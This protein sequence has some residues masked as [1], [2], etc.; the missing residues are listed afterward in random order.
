MPAARTRSPRSRELAAIHALKK[1]LG[2][3]DA[4]YRAMLVEVTGV[5]SAGKLTQSSERQRVIEHL[6]GLERR[7]GLAEPRPR[8]QP[9]PRLGAEMGF[10]DDDPPRVR[11]IRMM[12]LH[13]ADRGE[14]SAPTAAALNQWIHRQTGSMLAALG[15]TQLNAVIEQLK[16]WTARL[17]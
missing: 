5:D 17:D 1:K 13:L 11:K 8:P 10:R 9:T 7:M 4:D 12:W 14:V 15:G 3:D 6:R 16:E 2:M